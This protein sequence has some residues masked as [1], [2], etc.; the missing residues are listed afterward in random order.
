MFSKP[1]IPNYPVYT[2]YTP[3]VASSSDTQTDTTST[4]DQGDDAQ[5]I[6]AIA[7]RRSFPDTIQTSWRGVLQQGSWAPVRKS[8]LGE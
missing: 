7:R 2:P 8:L 5:H 4:G 3:P 1:D 6:A